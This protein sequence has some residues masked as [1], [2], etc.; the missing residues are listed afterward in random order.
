MLLWDFRSRGLG[1]SMYADTPVRS[2][3]K[4][5]PQLV[6]SFVPNWDEYRIQMTSLCCERRSLC[7]LENFFS[8]FTT[9]I[10]QF[11][12]LLGPKPLKLSFLVLFE[13]D[14]PFVNRSQERSLCA[15]FRF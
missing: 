8:T 13:P 6:V 4:K 7:F 10:F 3:V 11:Y 2:L 12:L 5:Q 14:T 1:S 9:V 15:F